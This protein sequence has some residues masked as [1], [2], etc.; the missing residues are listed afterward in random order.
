MRDRLMSLPVWSLFLVIAIPCAAVMSV[1]DLSTGGSFP[2]ALIPAAGFGILA[3]ASATLGL[4]LAARMEKRVFGDAPIDV[5]RQARRAART[6]PVPTDPEVRVAAF[7][8][9]Q[10]D[11][12]RV[13][14]SRPWMAAILVL[15]VVSEIGLAF[16]SSPWALL[17][18]VPLV[19]V[20][21]F[22][23]IVF[24]KRLRA[25]IAL[26]SAAQ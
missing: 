24:P 1:F 13:L 16:T 12:K 10:E 14:R 15:L 9:A 20:L 19:P 26:L 6:G 2:W 4:K 18:L 3:G 21:S 7:E 11:L 5:R 22:Q 17:V 8:L 23:L 25:R